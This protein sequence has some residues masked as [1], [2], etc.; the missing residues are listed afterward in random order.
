MYWSYEL[1]KITYPLPT[2]AQSYYLYPECMSWVGI[3]IFVFPS[4]WR[5]FSLWYLVYS[6]ERIHI[7]SFSL[8]QN[9]TNQTLL[10][11][12]TTSLI[13][14]LNSIILL[15]GDSLIWSLLLIFWP[16]YSNINLESQIIILTHTFLWNIF[17]TCWIKI[18]SFFV[19]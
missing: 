6:F 2:N 8:T 14:A 12:N 3:P 16:Y 7:L 9:H 4:P 13:A 15:K 10:N 19:I 18:E 11:C 17:L 5:P 1:F